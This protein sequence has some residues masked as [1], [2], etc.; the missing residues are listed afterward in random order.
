MIIGSTSDM[1]RKIESLYE[2][3][4]K[5]DYLEASFVLLRA[6]YDK[7]VNDHD[8]LSKELKDIKIEN[9]SLKAQLACTHELSVTNSDGNTPD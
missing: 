1:Q 6:K 9:T 4:K 8:C 2:K 7:L 5:T 3:L